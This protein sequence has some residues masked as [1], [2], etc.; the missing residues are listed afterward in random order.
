MKIPTILKIGGHK[1]KVSI[2]DLEAVECSGDW[3]STK[4]LIRIHSEET[5]SQQEATLLHEIM[6]AM[7]ANFT[8][9]F[10]HAFLE[11]FSQQLYQV[12]KDNKLHF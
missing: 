2:E 9:S 8:E 4:N 11:S 10:G 12:L 7:N 3:D 6:H 1:V 5:K